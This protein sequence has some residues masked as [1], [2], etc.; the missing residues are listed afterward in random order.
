[1]TTVAKTQR[2]VNDLPW[3]V[4]LGVLVVIG[5]AAWIVQLT[6]GFEVLG[7][8]QVI[9]WGAYIATFFFLAGIGGGLV[10]LAAAADLEFVPQMAPYRR[11]LLVGA[12]ACFVSAGIMILMDLGRP[13]RVINMLLSPNITSP[14]QWDFASLVLGVIVTAI[15]LFARPMGKV[16]PVLAAL[17]AALIVAVEG[18]ILSMSAGSP[19]W[20]GGVMPALF[21]VESLLAAAAVVLAL[22]TVPSSVRFLRGAVLLLLLMLVG[23]NGFELASVLYAGSPDTQAAATVLLTGSLAPLFWA[24]VLLGVVLPFLL[25]AGLGQNRAAVIGAAVLVLLG[26]LAA[27]YLVLTAGQKLPFLQAEASYVPTLVEVGGVIGV[28]GLAGL[29]YVAGRRL[30]GARPA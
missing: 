7:T 15:Y 6:R 18:W 16:L 17:V 22:V 24:Q 19:L 25:L 3:L 14:F 8:G 20:H 1:M 9:V 27:K 28:L 4:G 26:V 29:L 12:L 11:A 30:V 10:I 5:L 13:L 2:T 21:V 23:L